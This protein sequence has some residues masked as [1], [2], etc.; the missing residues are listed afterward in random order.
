M[1]PDLEFQGYCVK[2]EDPN[3]CRDLSKY[4]GKDLLLEEIEA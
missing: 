3:I 2:K 1:E 4:L